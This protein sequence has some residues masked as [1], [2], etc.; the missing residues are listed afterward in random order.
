MVVT[1]IRLEVV[2][3]GG[4]SSIPVLCRTGDTRQRE[5]GRV[6]GQTASSGLGACLTIGRE[7][8]GIEPVNR[9]DDHTFGIDGARFP[10]FP[11]WFSSTRNIV[12]WI[13]QFPQPYLPKCLKCCLGIVTPLPALWDEGAVKYVPISANQSDETRFAH[14]RVGR[15]EHSQVRYKSTLRCTGLR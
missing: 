5:G 14:P 3:E 12:R 6:H 1:F 2:R 10:M 15:D 13:E 4:L 11:A 9:R 7:I 8:Y